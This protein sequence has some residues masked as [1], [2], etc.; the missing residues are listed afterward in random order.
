MVAAHTLLTVHTVPGVPTKPDRIADIQM[1]DVLADLG[2]PTHH[3]MPGDEWE[4]SHAPT[5]FKHAQVAVADTAG[6]DLDIDVVRP[7]R[8]EFVLKGF[9]LSVGFVGGV[10]VDS[11][12]FASSFVSFIPG[13]GRSGR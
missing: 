10:G 1:C 3:L 4:L 6:S 2:N 7:K 13:F 9:E 12:Q 5:I 11:G 8:T